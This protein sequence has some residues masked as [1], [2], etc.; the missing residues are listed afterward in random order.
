[1]L[2]LVRAK[3]AEFIEELEVDDSRQLMNPE[4]SKWEKNLVSINARHGTSC[5]RSLEACKYK[6]QTLLPEYKRVAD[7]HK[8]TGVNS[9]LYFEMSFR[10]RKDKTLSKFFYPYVYRDMHEWLKHK[11]TMNPP[12]FWDLMNPRDGN[13][14]ILVVYTDT[15]TIDPPKDGE[16]DGIDPPPLRCTLTAALQHTTQHRA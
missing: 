12:H 11:S 13:Y 5:Y 2:A 1:M 14:M 8:E 6:W 4:M 15:G 16:S 9:M 3:R 10:E 7:V